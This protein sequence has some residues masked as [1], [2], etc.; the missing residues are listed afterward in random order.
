MIPFVEMWQIIL[1]PVSQWEASDH[2]A[3][4]PLSTGPPYPCYGTEPSAHT[5]T[6]F[7]A[8]LVP[9]DNPILAAPVLHPVLTMHTFH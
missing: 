8:V 5:V 4:E 7:R 9:L 1:P 6:D 3:E 2:R